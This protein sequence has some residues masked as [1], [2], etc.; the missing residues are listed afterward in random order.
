M[1][2]GCYCTVFIDRM[3]NSGILKMFIFL[4]K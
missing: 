4:F 3:I 1:E 2:D